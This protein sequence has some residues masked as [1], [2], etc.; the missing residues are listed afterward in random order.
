MSNNHRFLFFI[1]RNHIINKHHVWL[2]DKLEI[3][4][5]FWMPHP[6]NIVIG[7][8]VRIGKNC[9]IY[10][11]VT[12]GQN[13]NLYPIIGNNVIVYAGAKVIGGVNV[14]DGAIIGANALVINDVPQNTIVGGI[15]ARIIREKNENERFY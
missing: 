14:G 11:D 15:P 2:S 9:I 1:L 12:F 8:G 5:G 13:K 3:G 7:S 4:E 6:Q 10:Q